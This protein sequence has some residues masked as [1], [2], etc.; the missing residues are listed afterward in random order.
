MQRTFLSRAASQSCSQAIIMAVARTP[1]AHCGH[2]KLFASGWQKKVTTEGR[3]LR[4]AQ[5]HRVDSINRTSNVFSRLGINRPFR[6]FRTVA[7]S[8]Q[9]QRLRNDRLQKNCL[10][11]RESSARVDLEMIQNLGNLRPMITAEDKSPAGLFTRSS[12]FTIYR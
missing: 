1:R 4:A 2:N 11:P 8:W 7:S 3:V 10:A 5:S 9:G 6:V 12:C